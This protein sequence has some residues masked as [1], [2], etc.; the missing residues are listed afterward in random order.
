LDGDLPRGSGVA[1]SEPD[2]TGV[3][4]CYRSC[5]PDDQLPTDARITLA[6]GHWIHQTR[7]WKTS[8][9]EVAA[10]CVSPADMGWDK[11]LDFNS[12]YWLFSRSLLKPI[13]SPLWT[14]DYAPGR[15]LSDP[16]M[17]WAR[18]SRVPVLHWAND[19][20]VSFTREH[21]PLLVTVEDPDHLLSLNE[22]SC[23][24]L[25]VR[26]R[27][28]TP[29][30]GMS[31]STRVDEVQDVICQTESAGASGRRFTIGFDASYALTRKSDVDKGE[32]TV[33][34]SALAKIKGRYLLMGATN[35]LHLSMVDGR[36]IRRDWGRPVEG[37]AVSLTLDKDVYEFGSDIPLHIAL[38]NFSSRATIFA[39]DPYMDPPGAG[40]ELQ[41]SNGHPIPPGAGMMWSGHGFYHFLPGLV[42][43]VELTLRQMGFLP[44]HPGNYKVVATWNPTTNGALGWATPTN[45]L[46]VSSSPVTFRVVDHAAS[47]DPHPT[48]GIDANL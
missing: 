35:G 43:P 39:M 7:R 31:R 42:F 15:F 17:S 33:D 9:A 12:Y 13:C 36:F 24:R 18:G 37:V 32:Y 47:A 10:K 41:D 34:A 8:L 27:D 6:P 2:G 46:S 40:V 19:E 45:H 25:F 14:T 26:V 1:V 38:E 22:R 30:Q 29:S 20:G 5:E 16:L 4:V 28:A 3:K 44:D 11:T 23:P 21:I 48:G